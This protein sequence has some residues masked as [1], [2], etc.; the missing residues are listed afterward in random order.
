[1]AMVPH[2]R[3]HCSQNTAASSQLICPQHEK[4][5]L[6]VSPY[7]KSLRYKQPYM[8]GNMLLTPDPTP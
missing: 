1:M 6:V 3:Y 7:I 5:V 2:Q 8:L 4:M